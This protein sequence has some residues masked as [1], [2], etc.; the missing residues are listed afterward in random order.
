M[1]KTLQL[2]KIRL[3]GNT[4]PR[5]ELDEFLITEYQEAYAREAEMPPLQV[6]FDGASYWLWDGFHRRWA[7]ERA[8]LEK[9][10]CIVTEGTQ[11]DAQWASYG[12]NATHGLRRLNEDKQKAVRAALKHPFGVKLSDSQIA[13]HCGVS[14][15]F[16][17]KV[18]KELVSLETVTSQTTRT[19]RDGRT[20]NTAKIGKSKSAP[21]ETHLEEITST[22]N[23]T[24]SN[25]TDSNTSTPTPPKPTPKPK[26]KKPPKRLKLE[27]FKSSIGTVYAVVMHVSRKN[28]VLLE[29]LVLLTNDE[30]QATKAADYL[31]QYFHLARDDWFDGNMLTDDQLLSVMVYQYK[32][33]TEYHFY[34]RVDWSDVTEGTES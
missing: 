7:A 31:M 8:G 33:G 14:H 22:V 27:D 13:E 28:N 11:Q 4:Q 9:L 5:D 32:N 1:K 25:A 26:P 34:Y 12:A 10:P 3:D 20:I 6:M 15:P 2:D 19:G 30:G 17:G 16:V 29:R 21:K 23:E 24:R 18:R